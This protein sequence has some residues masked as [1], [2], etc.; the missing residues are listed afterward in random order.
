MGKLS[1]AAWLALL[2][3]ALYRKAISP[4]LH[5]QGY[6]VFALTYGDEPAPRPMKSTSCASVLYASASWR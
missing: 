5:N 2:V 4:L 6:C 1:R 3:I